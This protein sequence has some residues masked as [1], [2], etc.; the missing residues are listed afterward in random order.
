[1]LP[2]FDFYQLTTGYDKLLKMN[3]PLS[4]GAQ[5]LLEAAI[6]QRRRLELSCESTNGEKVAYKKILPVDI[7]SNN[8]IEQ[9]TILNTDNEGGILKLMINNS[10]IID[11]EAKDFLD[12]KIKFKNK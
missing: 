2:S 8:G 11:F 6:V 4:C 1:M 9:L 3:K 10:E 12:P 7:S 5:D